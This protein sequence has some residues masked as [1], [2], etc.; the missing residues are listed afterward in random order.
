MP[1]T[2]GM[3]RIL[4]CAALGAAIV[5]V[6]A[7]PRHVQT[8]DY[9]GGYAGTHKVAPQFAARWLTWAEV[10]T[11]G[12]K[13]L[14]PLGVKTIFYTNPNR[15]IA[16]EPMY[17]A[18][19]SSFAHDC[20]GN[21][22][23][24]TWRHDQYLMDPHSPALLS[25]WQGFVRE[26]LTESHFDAVFVDDSSPAYTTAQPCG[27][28]VDEWLDATIAQQRNLGFPIIYNALEDTQGPDVSREIALNASA[29]GG[30]MEECYSR[31]RPD[32]KSTGTQWLVTER[33]E[34][35]MA[36]QHKYFFCYGRDLTPAEQA[37][38]ARIYTYASFLLTYDLDTSV[39]WEYF[40]T[41][42]RGHVMPETALV[43]TGPVQQSV[44]SIESLRNRDG[45]FVREYREC[46]INARPAG[47]CVAAVNSDDVEHPLSIPG[48]NRALVLQG[49]GVFDGG[50]IAE[51]GPVPQSLAPSTAVIAFK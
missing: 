9:W 18:N 41:P 14:A 37:H 47:A 33:T 40:Q 2:T 27:F 1:F 15:I 44:P 22:I 20:S 34:I 21:R 24:S 8:S 3:H 39:L 16:G 43:P 36:R 26:H 23:T 51:N 7:V 12:A 46:Y 29:V 30:M 25:A 38:D 5:L 35:E 50:S 49:S 17:P 32:T 11:R 13:Q 42:S 45:I 28:R 6:G 31:L 19:E 48:Y 4:A 10:D